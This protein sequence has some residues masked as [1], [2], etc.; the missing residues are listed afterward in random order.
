[1]FPLAKQPFGLDGLSAED[2]QRRRD[3]R[4]LEPAHANGGVANDTPAVASQS[5][6]GRQAI[7]A[8]M[9]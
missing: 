9:G 2:L 3:E 4:D 5:I 8:A 1:V 7:E 6:C